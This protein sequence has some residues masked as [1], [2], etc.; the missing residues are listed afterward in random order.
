M[1]LA[2]LTLQCA[3]TLTKTEVENRDKGRQVKE[4]S[5]KKLATKRVGAYCCCA[6]LGCS[7]HAVLDITDDDRS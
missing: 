2:G 7:Q 1:S 4:K 5:D 3:E 6:Q